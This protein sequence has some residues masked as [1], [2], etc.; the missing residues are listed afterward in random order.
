MKKIN[1]NILGMCYALLTVYLCFEEIVL[2]EL[3]DWGLLNLPVFYLCSFSLMWG[4][5]GKVLVASVFAG[6]AVC[7]YM[8]TVRKKNSFYLFPIIIS[9]L[10]VFI[11]VFL[12]VTRIE[13]YLIIVFKAFGLYS[14][15]RAYKNGKPVLWTDDE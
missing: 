9:S 12:L 13:P 5:A 3:D 4:T 15:L 11:N 7:L 1:W 8:V 6:Y 2:F 10:D 14:M